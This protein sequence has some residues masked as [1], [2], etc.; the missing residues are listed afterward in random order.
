MAKILTGRKQIQLFVGRDWR[1]IMRWVSCMGFPA[2]KI[3]GIWESDSDLIVAWRKDQI[4]GA[5][6]GGQDIK[7][8]NS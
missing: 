2:R 1:L 7:I 4:L 3:D 8:H 6:E 5:F